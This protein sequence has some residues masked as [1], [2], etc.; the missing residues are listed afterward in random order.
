[1]T[2]AMSKKFS[3]R[4]FF[5]PLFFIL[6]PFANLIRYLMLKIMKKLRLPGDDRPARAAASHL[7]EELILPSGFR[8]FSDRGF[9]ELA[10]FSTLPTTEQDRVFNELETAGICL[11]LFCLDFADALVKPEDYHFWRE[12]KDR[13]PKE[14]EENLIKMGAEKESAHLYQDL[15]SMRYQEYEKTTQEAIDIWNSEEPRF[16]EL[17][18]EVAKHSAARVHAIAIGAADHI[19]RGKLKKVDRLPSFL[20]SWLLYLNEDIGKFIK[21]L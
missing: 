9:R 10:Q 18:T 2:I 8:I 15:I 5:R 14:F 3:E 11:A 12:V 21:K 20:I 6:R 4:I 16:R 17:Q 1:M 13:L 7:L 19:R